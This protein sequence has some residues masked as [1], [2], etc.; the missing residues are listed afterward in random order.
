MGV[1]AETF[2]PFLSSH[3]TNNGCRARNGALKLLPDQYI[4]FSFEKPRPA[5]LSGICLASYS[6]KPVA[7]GS[8][9]DMGWEQSC[10]RLCQLW[11]K[12]FTGIWR[13]AGQAPS[14]AI[15]WGP[16]IGAQGRH[17][18][19]LYGALMRV[20]GGGWGSSFGWARVQYRHQVGEGCCRRGGVAGAEPPHKGGPNRPDRTTA[21]V[22]GQW[23]V[24]ATI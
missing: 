1:K 16:L 18:A 20:A 7:E 24:T 13:D 2:E 23:L 6:E 19:C 9:L 3:I 8:I 12:L 14:L 21:V 5:D 22:S 17:K 10:G 11:Q 4:A 15:R